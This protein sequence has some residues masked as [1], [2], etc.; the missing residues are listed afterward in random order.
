ML[1]LN[2]ASLTSG[3][4][5]HSTATPVA[6][7]ADANYAPDDLTVKVTALP[8]QDP[9][10]SGASSTVS[11]ETTPGACSISNLKAPSSR[12]LGWVPS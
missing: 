7:V 2:P 5:G 9:R 10:I 12:R 3:E 4:N 1:S 8:S 11:G 6:R